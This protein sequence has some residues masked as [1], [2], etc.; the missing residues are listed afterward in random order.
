MGFTEKTTPAAKQWNKEED[1][2]AQMKSDSEVYYC[3]KVG[4]RYEQLLD[5]TGEQTSH[6]LLWMTCLGISQLIDIDQY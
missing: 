1:R 3:G 6:G 5:K 4:V 2:L